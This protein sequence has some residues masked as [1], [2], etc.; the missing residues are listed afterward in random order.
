MLKLLENCDVYAPEHLGPMD[1]LLAGGRIHQ[2]S[3]RLDAWRAMPEVQKEDMRGAIVCPGLVDA[4]V[5]ITGG[6]GE[7]GPTSRMPELRFEDFVLNGVTTVLGLLGTDGISRSLENLLFKCRALSA[8]GLTVRLLTGH[9]SYPTTTLTGSVQRD[10]ALL[11]HFIGVKIAISD[12]RGANVSPP[13]LARLAADAR[14]GGMLS[15]KPGLTVIHLGASKRMMEPLF[16]ALEQSDVPAYNF[17]PTHCDRSPALLMEAL[18]FTQMGGSIDLTADTLDS[19]EGTAKALMFLL[20]KGVDKTRVTIS[21]DAGGSLPVFD[22]DGRPI[23][24]DQATPA[25]LLG[26]LRRLRTNHKLNLED[27]L[28]F[29]TRNPARVLG[30]EGR[31]GVLEKGADADVLVLDQ[32]LRVRQVYLGGEKVA[33]GGVV[34]S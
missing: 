11:E 15:G 6:G 2:M 23:G 16:L 25:T 22:A 30:F 4:H 24:I 33:V 1:M 19:Q 32:G 29:F 3:R 13:E 34:L 27:A 9:Y 18:R 5:H 31:K 28:P 26:E 12:H 10:I 8:Q 20:D 7:L 14:V 17:Y 21:S